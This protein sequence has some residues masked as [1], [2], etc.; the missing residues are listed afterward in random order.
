MNKNYGKV[1]L[2]TYKDGSMEIPNY[3]YGE[4]EVP[5]VINNTVSSA[6]AKLLAAGFNVHIEGNVN[7]DAGAGAVIVSQT[8]LGEKWKRGSVVTIECR[9]LDVDDEGQIENE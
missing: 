6:V 7:Y 5:N 1:L 8:G 3:N 2:Y 9:H 4:Q